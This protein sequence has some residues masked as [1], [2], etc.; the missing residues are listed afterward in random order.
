MT[1][2]AAPSKRASPARTGS[3]LI[4]VLVAL[5]ILT[6]VVLGI[7]VGG[8]SSHDLSARRIESART[9]YASDS[10]MHIAIREIVTSSDADGDGTIGSVAAG[11]LASGV[12]L[13]GSTKAAASVSA[14]SG[15]YTITAS[16]CSGSSIHTQTLTLVHS[17][18]TAGTPGLYTEFYDLGNCFDTLAD[19]DWS[20]PTAVG[21]SPNVDLPYVASNSTPR[22]SGG[23]KEQ[24]AIRYRGKINIPTAGTWTF[25]T[26]SDDNSILKINGAVVVDNDGFHSPVSASGSVSLPAGYADFEVQFHECDTSSMVYVQWQGPGVPSLTIIPQS[27]FTCTVET[28]IPGLFGATSI[29]MYGNGT[30][31]G[32]NVDGYD[33][34]VG[35]YGGS[36]VI[37]TQ[38]IAATNSNASA[39]WKLT[40]GAR[41]QGDV[42]V[43]PTG[44]PG[45]VITTSNSA[46]IT[47]ARN[48]GNPGIGVI[49]MRAPSNMPSSSGSLGTGGT[50]TWNTNLRYSSVQFWGTS[51]T[52]TISGNITVLVD[53]DFSIG[54][55]VQI[56][57][58][59]GSSL[60]LY[61]GGNVNFWNS[62]KA[63][64]PSTSPQR[65]Q[66]FMYGSSKN[67]Q[68]SD[69]AQVCAVVQNT[70]GTLNFYGTGSPTAEFFG[71]YL[72]NAVYMTNSAKFHV[73]VSFGRASGSTSAPSGTTLSNWTQTR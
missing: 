37:T 1:R 67:M 57:I 24:F 19:I 52:L 59:S 68:I 31:G 33:S 65:F 18:S 6:F 38:Y 47:G 49:P 30:V 42:H 45:S 15:T 21:I 12:S 3:V 56:L 62:C 25:L 66:I 9:T 64:M 26:R 72:G 73:D 32:L 7:V 35:A 2:S 11:N 48:N 29:T 53:N 51:T 43:G 54:D 40:D 16:G 61:V 44:A 39:A 70:Y 34:T 20:T 10:A 23:P 8:R 71:A 50:V 4:S 58:P 36:N 69:S 14:A 63:N 55:S 22:W 5:F 46:A 60:T 27:A 13:L 17:T 28:D 41:V